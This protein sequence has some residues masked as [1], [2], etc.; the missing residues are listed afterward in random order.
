M[1]KDV[2]VDIEYLAV[3]NADLVRERG[4][5][6]NLKDKGKVL[7]MN[8]W[9][10]PYAENPTLNCVTNNIKPDN[11][12][13]NVDEPPYNN[14][15]SDPVNNNKEVAKELESVKDVIEVV[16]DVDN[17]TAVKGVEIEPEPPPGAMHRLMYVQSIVGK[18]NQFG[19][20]LSNCSSHKFFCLQQIYADDLSSVCGLQ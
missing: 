9:T 14:S 8:S 15:T 17:K 19:M 20:S 11:D 13:I 16:K 10:G 3:H 5:N 12:K 2:N 1:V 18:E 6:N 7:P 4:I